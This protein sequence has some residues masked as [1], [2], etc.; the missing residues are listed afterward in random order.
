MSWAPRS[1]GRG[2]GAQAPGSEGGLECLWGKGG[3]TE[4]R[5]GGEEKDRWGQDRPEQALGTFQPQS[6]QRWGRQRTGVRISGLRTEQSCLTGK[7]GL[8][9]CLG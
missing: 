8:E 9:N 1:Q 6:G 7:E 3:L 2:Q 5:V 4:D